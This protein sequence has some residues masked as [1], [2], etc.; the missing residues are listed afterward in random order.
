[1]PE[2]RERMIQATRNKLSNIP[3]RGSVLVFA[4]VV[5]SILFMIAAAYLLIVQKSRAASTNSLNRVETD[6]ATD[7]G[8]NEAVAIIRQGFING[9]PVTPDGTYDPSQPTWHNF[10]DVPIING[11]Q[12]VNPLTHF[13]INDI[14]DLDGGYALLF[15]DALGDYNDT[16]SDL[17]QTKNFFTVSPLSTFAYPTGQMRES[18]NGV[19]HRGIAR[20]KVVRGSPKDVYATNGASIN[21]LLQVDGLRGEYFVWIDDLDAKLYANPQDWNID[22]DN[23][24]PFP[25]ATDIERTELKK[26]ILDNLNEYGTNV[27]LNA[28]AD[29]GY[30]ISR[31]T[32]VVLTENDRILLTDPVEF[33]E[34]RKFNSIH[35]LA[36]ELPSLDA[37]LYPLPVGSPSNEYY[38]MARGALQHYFTVY[39]DTPNRN[40]SLPTK[41][42]K[43]HATAININTAS[44]EVIAA[45]LS[46]IPN[47][48]GLPL[49]T[50]EE[51]PLKIAKRII[52]KRPFLCRMDF[53][54][55]LAAHI[56]GSQ[57]DIEPDSITF[58]LDADIIDALDIS[59]VRMIYFGISRRWGKGYFDPLD[60]R[61]QT[62]ELTLSQYLEVPRNILTP[63]YPDIYKREVAG[64]PCW[65]NEPLYQMERFK[66]F[67]DGATR[68][69]ALLTPKE[70][71]TFVN[72]VTCVFP[73]DDVQIKFAGSIGATTDIVVQDF[74]PPAP[75]PPA[76]VI[77]ENGLQTIPQGDDVFS[78]DGKKILCGPNGIAETW[79]SANRPSYYSFVSE[80]DFIQD[81][82][83]DIDQALIDAAPPTMSAF[84]S[85]TSITDAA[86]KDLPFAAPEK[87]SE[88]ESRVLKHMKFYY[89]IP[90]TPGVFPI[91]PN[92][93][94]A[95]LD[96]LISWRCNPTPLDLPASIDRRSGFYQVAFD[97]WSPFGVLGPLAAMGDPE[98]SADGYSSA[99][100][101]S[102]KAGNGDANWS[103]QFAYRSRFYGIYVLGR[104]LISSNDDVQ[105]VAPGIDVGPNVPIIQDFIPIL[106]ALPNGIQTTPQGDDQLTADGSSIN[107]GPNGIAETSV[108]KPLGEKRL[109]A[110]YDALNDKILWQRSMLS[111]RRS[112]DE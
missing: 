103:P 67:F 98:G 6:L 35:E 76:P 71:N 95:T 69:D 108:S 41:F 57:F 94:Y 11:R 80:H 53:E 73:N 4:V 93:S 36:L 21:K 15:Y 50:D 47:Q 78:A 29:W 45:A 104:G 38:S 109:E 7:A 20:R 9:I 102:G 49:F 48:D 25:A 96:N 110:V 3:H 24:V 42:I 40:S 27:A 92:Y 19:E 17:P 30:G 51:R 111:T 70:F 65:P 64:V 75:I 86:I 97:D 44:E 112:L 55:F 87:I 79:V 66:Y 18:P 60:S 12:V 72:S 39:S 63:E 10:E 2:L 81:F 101:D 56:T 89:R 14:G 90:L 106:P 43:D 84:Y 105:V 34:S 82:W 74:T 46:N 5:L 58:P 100:L 62:P 91:A 13:A 61:F 22:I 31:Y 54:D 26:S 59:Y 33:P 99:I 1:V 8:L 16:L 28:V 68:D 85:S 52:E 83:D 32:G 77:P 37:L 23:T 88:A 107:S